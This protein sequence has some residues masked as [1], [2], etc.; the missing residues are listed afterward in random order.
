MKILRYGAT[1]D[2][3][4]DPRGP[5]FDEFGRFRKRLSNV[6]PGPAPQGPPTG[7]L[8]SW[9]KARRLARAQEATPKGLVQR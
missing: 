2:R 7:E 3:L 1:T 6:S 9:A 8:L 4:R 5:A